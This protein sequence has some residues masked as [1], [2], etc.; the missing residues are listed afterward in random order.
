[1]RLSA[2]CVPTVVGCFVFGC[3]IHHP[4]RLV[5]VGAGVRFDG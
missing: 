1:M 4:G 5:P 3:S 2:V